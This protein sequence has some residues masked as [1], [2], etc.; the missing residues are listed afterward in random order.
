M[1]FENTLICASF[2][3]EGRFETMILSAGEG[4]AVVRAVAAATVARARV[5]GLATGFPRTWARAD[6]RRPVPR[7]TR[8]LAEIICLKK[9]SNKEGQ[10][11]SLKRKKRHRLHQ[12]TC[13]WRV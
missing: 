1:P 4:V 9:K 3:S 5:A 11:G 13:P 6:P 12:E 8:G 10:G 2:T 7:R